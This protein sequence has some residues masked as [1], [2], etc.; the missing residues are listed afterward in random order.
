MTNHEDPTGDEVARIR[1]DAAALDAMSNATAKSERAARLG[2]EATLV[3]AEAVRD[4]TSLVALAVAPTYPE[5]PIDDESDAPRV[6]EVDEHPTLGSIA[7]ELEPGDVVVL[8]DGERLTITAAGLSE[9]SAWLEVHDG[10][11]ASRRWVDS[12]ALDGRRVAERGDVDPASPE[13]PAAAEPEP[14]ADDLVGSTPT[15]DADDE[16]DEVDPDA[17]A[18]LEG[19]D[20]EDGEPRDFDVVV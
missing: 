7:H 4:L 20:D 12:L 19:D 17:E 2:I 16:D 13:P 18:F 11:A 5:A 9:G 14:E 3:L 15:L 1:R 8:D 10:T 6:P